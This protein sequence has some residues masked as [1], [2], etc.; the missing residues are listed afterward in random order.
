M[1]FVVLPLSALGSAQFNI[2]TYITG[3]VGHTFLVG[4][5]IAISVR[6]FAKPSS[7]YTSR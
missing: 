1:Y 7:L 3:T 5:P 4:L 2:A 6:H